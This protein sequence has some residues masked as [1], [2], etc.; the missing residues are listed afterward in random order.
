M[1]YFFFQT[2]A[3]FNFKKMNINNIKK[4]IDDKIDVKQNM[5]Y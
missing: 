4:L 1:I 5:Y 3:Y 2:A